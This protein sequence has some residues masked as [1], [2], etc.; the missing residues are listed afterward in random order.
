MSNQSSYDVRSIATTP[1]GEVA[2]LNAQVDLFWEQESALYLRHGLDRVASL[3]DCG[4]GT[5]HTAELITKLIPGITIDAI[6][7]EE[8]QVTVAREQLGGSNGRIRLRQG[9][10]TQIPFPDNTF[11]AV[12]S[13]L[14]LEHLP[15]PVIALREALRVLKPGGVAWFTD[16]DFDYHV[17]TFPVVAEIEDFYRS[18]CTAREQ[19]GG[20]PKIG[21]QLPV[22]MSKAGFTEVGLEVVCAHS[23]LGGDEIFA[24]SEGSGIARQ[25][26]QTGHLSSDR[27]EEL[28]VKWTSMVRNREHSIFRQLFVG[29]GRKPVVT[30]RGEP[31]AIAS[32]TSRGG[33]T[34][35]ADI[36]E[37]LLRF[38]TATFAVDAHEFDHDRSLV[39]QG[40]VDSFGLLE[41]ASFLTDTF[42]IEVPDSDIDRHN[43]G[44]VNRLV[45]YTKLKL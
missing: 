12:V 7:V 36:H 33:S 34:T 37:E 28:V 25:L 19:E 2:R 14:V 27:Y 3:L 6:D 10:I 26:V 24:R 20:N 16:N 4:C 1:E 18:Y 23:A 38:I 29:I 17:R 41:I 39:D 30:G 31:A 43:F 40:I 42:G 11:D 35:E 9:S 5:G 15:D 32:R 44:S 21:R 45:R 13:R 22:L 8:Y